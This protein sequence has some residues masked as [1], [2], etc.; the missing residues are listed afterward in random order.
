MISKKKIHLQLIL[1][2]TQSGHLIRNMPSTL[3]NAEIY[4]Y[5]PGNLTPQESE[6]LTTHTVIY[7]ML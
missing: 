2:E 6:P 1:R 3:P 5:L 7:R 4:H